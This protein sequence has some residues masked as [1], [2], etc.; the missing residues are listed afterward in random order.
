M[1]EHF[2]N[3]KVDRE[4]RPDLDAVY[5]DSVVTL[6]GHG[7][8]PMT[9]FLTPEGE[10]F[11][12]GTYYPP[13]PRHGTAQLPAGARGR[14]RGVPRAARGRG[15]LGRRPR[16]RCSPLKRAESPRATRSRTRCC[17][18]PRAGCARSSIPSGAVGVARRSS[19]RRPALEFLL[20]VRLRTGD[21]WALG[22]VTKTL[23]RMAAGGMYDLV[24]GGF[25]RYSVDERWLVPHF[26]KMLYDNALLA[27]AYL[28]AWSVGREMPATGRSRSVRSTTSCASSPCQRGAFASAQDADTEGVEGLTFT[29]TR[30]AAVGAR[31]RARRPPAAVRARAQHSPR[32]PRARRARAPP[33][34]EGGAPRSRCATTRRSRPGT[35]WR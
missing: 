6:T 17:P 2:V 33:R 13:E 5:M 20:R 11:Y 16:G 28:H 1:N 29:W 25:H 4:E 19:R 12:G 32:R 15:P 21:D 27:S 3:V 30:G 7:G 22:A 9:V 34:G 24:G 23:D 14:S 26:E 35:G 10:P 8:W 18:T 31:P